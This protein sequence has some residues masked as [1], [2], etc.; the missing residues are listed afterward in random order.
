MILWPEIRLR[1]NQR[2]VI[3]IRKD[4]LNSLIIEAR[5]DLVNHPYILALDIWDIHHRTRQKIRRTRLVNV[6]DNI[7]DI[8]PKTGRLP[9]ILEERSKT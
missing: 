3:A 4:L 2:V 7:I 6:Y 9:A 8:G 1:D 5:T